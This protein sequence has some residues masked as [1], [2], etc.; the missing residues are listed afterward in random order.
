[1]I[2]DVNIGLLLAKGTPRVPLRPKSLDTGNTTYQIRNKE[3]SFSTW[4]NTLSA[5]E[6]GDLP[7]ESAD[8]VFACD[9]KNMDLSTNGHTSL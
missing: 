9:R 4:K 7:K 6:I 5:P 3:T 8:N 1:M 2:C